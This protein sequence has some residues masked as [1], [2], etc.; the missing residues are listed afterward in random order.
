MPVKTLLVCLMNKEHADTVLSAAVP[1][2]RANNAHLIGLHT[3]E[4]LLVYP[5]IAMHVPDEAFTEFHESQKE[6]AEAI[7]AIFK[8][9]TDNEDF[10]SEWR[11]VR[12]E[13][14]SAAQR[15]IESAHAA[16][17]VIMPNSDP[18]I[19]RGDQR[20]VQARVIRNGGRPVIVVP[21]NY[22]GAPIG[23][24]VVVGWSN[25]REAAR[26]A[27][28]LIPVAHPGGTISVVRIDGNA[29]DELSDFE[30]IDIAGMYD[31]HGLRAKMVHR[32]KGGDKV[33]KALMQY[34]FESGADLLVTGAF[35][36][37]RAYD[38]VVGAVTYQLLR[39]AK[40]PV[41]FSS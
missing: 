14:T 5:G 34:A 18:D 36:H 40:I 9:H 19:D 33:A 8:R 29:G 16:D 22:D 10:I 35:G 32:E 24:N 6:E 31:R 41:L 38:F 12:A 30:A 17:L 2:A 26:A 11:L 4:A 23:A 21:S 20:D 3:V 1:L 25:T 15:M 13:A 37:S 7:E 27:H 28:D 39:E